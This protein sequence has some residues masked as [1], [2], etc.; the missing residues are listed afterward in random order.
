MVW[1]RIKSAIMNLIKIKRKFLYYFFSRSDTV[2]ISYRILIQCFIFSHTHI[3]C[4]RSIMDIQSDFACGIVSLE[5]YKMIKSTCTEKKF[6]KKQHYSFD[7]MMVIFDYKLCSISLS[8]SSDFIWLN[9][10]EWLNIYTCQRPLEYL[11]G[12][13]Y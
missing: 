6:E 1:S 13:L 7:K 10:Q 9:V 5:T 11:M 12:D 2:T 4:I 8:H 3:I